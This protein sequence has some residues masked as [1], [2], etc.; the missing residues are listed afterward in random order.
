M[1]RDTARPSFSSSDSRVGSIRSMLRSCASTSPRRALDQGEKREERVTGCPLA[2][3]P[4]T[5]SIGGSGAGD[6]AMN[7]SRVADELTKEQRRGDR[8]AVAV[9]GLLQVGDVALDLL[10]EV[11]EKRH[12]PHLFARLLQR[13]PELARPVFVAGV[14]TRAR[15]AKGHDACAR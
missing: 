7:P 12:A 14:P 11:F 8:T 1:A 6:V 2:L 5:R 4:R 13:R 3:H 10:A 15:R 9:A